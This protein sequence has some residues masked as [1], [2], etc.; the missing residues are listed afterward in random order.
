MALEVENVPASAG[1]TGDEGRT[2]LPVLE[3]QEMRVLP[4]GWE[5]PLEKGMA[6]HSGILACRL[7]WTEEPDGLQ[8]LGSQIGRYD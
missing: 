5:D 1:D 8:S 4:L 2:C 3:T 7:S 6:A